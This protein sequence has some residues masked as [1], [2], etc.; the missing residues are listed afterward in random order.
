MTH[1]YRERVVPGVWW[2]TV[3]VL[4][5]VMVSVAY[6]AALGVGVGVIV[7]VVG[8]GLVIVGTQAATTTIVVD[9]HRLRVG[10]ALVPLTALG[11]VRVLTSDDMA[12]AR[13]GLDPQIHDTVFTRQPP[14]GPSQG[15]WVQVTDDSDPHSGWLVA[16]RHAED[17]GRELTEAIAG[18][19]DH[20]GE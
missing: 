9:D 20:A 5:V 16:S 7:F 1:T 11:T 15:I 6:G 8:A 13:R 12:R 17:L 19:H 4:I 10:H 14:W 18:P 2:I 3:V